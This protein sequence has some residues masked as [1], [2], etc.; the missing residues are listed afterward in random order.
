MRLILK[1]K[2]QRQKAQAKDCA[3]CPS[4]ALQAWQSLLT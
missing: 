2:V 4:L 1:K 3:V